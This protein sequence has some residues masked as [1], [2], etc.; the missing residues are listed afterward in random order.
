MAEFSLIDRFC[1]NTGAV[2]PETKLSVGDDAAVVAIPE[3]M[4]LAISVDTMVSG[5]HFFPDAPPKSI[6]HKLLAVNLSD[7]A[8]MG[9][10]PKWATMTLTAPTVDQAW[11]TDFSTSL[12]ELAKYYGV[13]LIGCLLYTS[14][15]PRDLSTSRMPSSA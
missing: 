8:A 12:N 9:A 13:Q 15:S 6:A 2:H 10:Q 5:V 1:K 4:E 3:G 11:L 7:M 14:P